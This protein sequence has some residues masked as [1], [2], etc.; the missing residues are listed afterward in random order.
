MQ[1]QFSA[2]DEESNRF[3]DLQK[4]DVE[5]LHEVAINDLLLLGEVLP[6]VSSNCQCPFDD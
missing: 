2:F 3:I 5:D 1:F 6:K 4:G